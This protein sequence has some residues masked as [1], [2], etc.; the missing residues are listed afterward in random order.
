MPRLDADGLRIAGEPS[1]LRSTKFDLALNLAETG[2]TIGGRIEYD[3]ELF[4][5]A[6]IAGLAGGY[7]AILGAVAADPEIPL[8]RLAACVA[9]PARRTSTSLSPSLPS[10]SSAAGEPVPAS[11]GSQ[12]SPATCEAVQAGSSSQRSSAAGEPGPAGSGSP[13]SPA[14]GEAAPAGT[15]SQLFQ[16]VLRATAKGARRRA[17]RP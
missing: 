5:A 6:T 10:S 14:A 16:E 2:G 7:Q 3:A 1:R 12:L 8:H 9:V 17:A 11:A 13:P 15:G 4:E